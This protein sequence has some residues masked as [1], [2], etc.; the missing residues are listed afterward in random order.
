MPL[1][2]TEILMPFVRFVFPGWALSVLGALLL[3]VAASYWTV[4]GD[5]VRL[6]AKPGWWRALVALGFLSF[7]LGIVWQ[8]GGYVQIG[9]VTWPR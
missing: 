5:G 8:L 7:I 6:H 1:W 9:A 3:L 2:P 4:K